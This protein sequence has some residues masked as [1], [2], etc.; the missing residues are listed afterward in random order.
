M[1]V[2]EGGVTVGVG[3]NPG[4]GCVTVRV[5]APRKNAE[6]VLKNGSYSEGSDGWKSICPKIFVGI[7]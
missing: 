5:V 3:A 7:G 2:V 6:T 4:G 1:C